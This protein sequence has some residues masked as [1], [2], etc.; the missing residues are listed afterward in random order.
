MDGERQPGT[1]INFADLAGG[2]TLTAF[3][4]DRHVTGPAGLDL[5]ATR[6]GMT[7]AFARAY[8]KAGL[9]GFGG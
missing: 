9:M 6:T 7:A 4:L 5:S 8:E 2:F 1:E 3:F